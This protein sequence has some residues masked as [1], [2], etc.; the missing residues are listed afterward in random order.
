MKTELTLNGFGDTIAFCEAQ[1]LSKVFKAYANN[2][3]REEITEVGFNP[4]SGYVYIALENG[5][6]IASILGEEAEYIITSWLTGKE[7]FLETYEDALNHK[8][9]DDDEDE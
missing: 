4:H 2:C 9:T 1:G 7:A 8:F 3:T 6:Q 5:I